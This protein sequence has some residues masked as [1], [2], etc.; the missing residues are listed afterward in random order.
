MSYTS[1]WKDAVART[2]RHGL[3]V[4]PHTLTSERYFS[5][6]KTLAEFPY[7]LRDGL[8]ELDIADVAAKCMSI[9]YAMIP[10][11]EAWLGVPPL[12]TIGWVDDGTDRGLFRFDESFIT[13]KIR[14]GHKSG[15]INI[16]A[17]LTLPSLE[18]IDVAL[19]TSFAVAQ[20]KPEWLGS[21]LTKYADDLQGVAYKP[22][23]VGTDFLR[24]T[25][26][27]VEI[28]NL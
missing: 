1:E 7:V 23:L 14:S 12:Y 20:K 18:I 6:P 13:E 10:V 17:W 24:K 19:M 25:G 28:M 26:L 4:P 21:A 16:H 5:N 9:H 22:M 11:V 3:D 2:E 8:G 27:L 15:S